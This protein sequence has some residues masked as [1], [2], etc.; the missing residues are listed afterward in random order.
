MILS[1]IT[2]A[3]AK[4]LVVT[5]LFIFRLCSFSFSDMPKQEKDIS[6]PN[7]FIL[8]SPNTQYTALAIDQQ[9]VSKYY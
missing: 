6:I 3:V 1:R 4:N 2:F 5:I 7:C 9:R 8:T